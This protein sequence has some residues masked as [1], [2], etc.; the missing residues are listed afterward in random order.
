MSLDEFKRIISVLPPHVRIDFSGFSE[1][2][3]NP[4]FSGFLKAAALIPNKIALYSTFQ[5]AT[6]TD[7]A[8][9]RY[10]INIGQLTI[11]TIHLPDDH[12]NMP[13]FRLSSDYI[14][15]L[16]EALLLPTSSAMTMS[17]NATIKK[18]VLD[19]LQ[20]HPSWSQIKHK[21]PSSTFTAGRRA[22]SLNTERLNDDDLHA[23]V[24]WQCAISCRSTP[25]YDRN[26]VIP[27]GN[28]YLC[29][30]DYGL[31]HNLG[32]I[33]DGYY[34]LYEAEELAKV[35]SSNLNPASSYSI[36]KS[37]ENVNCHSLGPSH[38]WQSA[39]CV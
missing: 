24:E 30:M 13:G 6:L 38:I 11:L 32:N 4:S 28:V 23:T 33:H 36:C 7:I 35:I 12:N 9:I 16:A 18:S 29:C 2:F 10:L 21:L 20:K 31:K 8:I 34:K 37:C 26:V 17:K 22:G 5:G 3:S 39:S 27:G 15:V 19:M 25:F 1:P 14:D